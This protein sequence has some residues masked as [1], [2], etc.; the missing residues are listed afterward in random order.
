MENHAL[1]SSVFDA[2]IL[3]DILKASQDEL[4]G[5]CSD[6]PHPFPMNSISLKKPDPMKP[7]AVVN[8]KL[9]KALMK[10]PLPVSE[11]DRI[12]KLRN[13]ASAKRSRKRETDNILALQQEAAALREYIDL[14]RRQLLIELLSL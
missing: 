9:E 6:M 8:I 13:I 14:V 11:K 12:R 1:P 3:D 2:S 5:H 10:P 4:L 7:A